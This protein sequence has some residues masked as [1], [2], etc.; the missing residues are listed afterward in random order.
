MFVLPSFLFHTLLFAF[1]KQKTHKQK[2]YQNAVSKGVNLCSFPPPPRT[3]L[4]CF[5]IA[6]HISPLIANLCFLLPHRN[7]ME[8]LPLCFRLFIVQ[9]M[10]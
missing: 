1:V 4:P 10:S 6:L 3:M 7:T 9:M 8:Q 2:V 5:I